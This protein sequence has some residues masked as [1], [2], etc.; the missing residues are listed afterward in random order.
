MPEAQPGT[1]VSLP[2]FLPPLLAVA[3]V[4]WALF[5]IHRRRQRAFPCYSRFGLSLLPATILT[6]AAAYIAAH[7]YPT[8]DATTFV[9]AMLWLAAM[10][11]ITTFFALRTPDDAGGENDGS[12]DDQPE[13]PWWP[14]FER[15]LRDYMRRRPRE[16]AKPPKAPASV[17]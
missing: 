16:P 17:S 8:D 11:S 2:D 7:R 6:D 4:L 5:L 3:L 15:D 1:P 12:P 10:L 9:L 14:D 13:P